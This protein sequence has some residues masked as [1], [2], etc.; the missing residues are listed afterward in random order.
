MTISL[1]SIILFCG[2]LTLFSNIILSAFSVP[3]ILTMATLGFRDVILILL[4]LLWPALIYGR[5]ASKYALSV[6]LIY[7]CS[8]MVFAFQLILVPNYA[9]IASSIALSRIVLALPILAI[10]FCIIWPAKHAS[11]HRFVALGFKIFLFICIV[12]SILLVSGYYSSYLSLIGFNEYMAS[13][14][15]SSFTAFGFFGSRIIT[16]LFNASVGGVVL[17]FMFGFYLLT[18]QRKLALITLIPLLFTV[19]KTGFL[20]ALI[21][22]V[23]RRFSAYGFLITCFIYFFFALIFSNMDI[24]LLPIPD[25]LLV[26]LASVKYHMNGLITGL[27]SFLL[28]VGLGNAGTVP[29]VDMPKIIGAESGFGVGLGTSGIFYLI[30]FLLAGF[31]L[32]HKFPKSGFLMVAGYTLVAL[33]NEAASSFYIWV[34][35]FVLFFKSCNSDA[36]RIK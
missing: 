26:H 23:F 27:N 16:P 17:A 29:G 25:N 6:Y 8:V 13:K 31:A 10:L 20:V 9:P 4:A 32:A 15:T 14:N 21:F 18:G 19:S 7:L 11:R 36:L 34:P 33:T 22:L 2:F 30:S 5:L 3:V 35:L 12:E 24:Y 28:P 1:K